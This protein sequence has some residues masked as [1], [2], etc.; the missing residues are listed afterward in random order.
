VV[1][2]SEYECDWQLCVSFILLFLSFSFYI[3]LNSAQ[4]YPSQALRVIFFIKKTK[5]KP[6]L[7]RLIDLEV[8]SSRHRVSCALFRSDVLS[9]KAKSLFV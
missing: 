1:T 4:P 2:V 7:T 8:L 5:L 3:K 9:C 6:T